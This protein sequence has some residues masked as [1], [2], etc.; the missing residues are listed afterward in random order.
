MAEWVPC[1]SGLIEADVIRWSEGIWKQ[2]PRKRGRAVNLGD[3]LVIA[4]V[5]RDDGEWVDLVVHDC[6]VASEMT[7]H[8]VA[9]LTTNA[10]VR[11]KRHTIEKGSPGRLLWS[12]E[13]V[14]A[15]LVCRLLP[16]DNPSASH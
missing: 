12:D 6:T 1:S 7:R 11:R 16:T 13:T 2:P 15:L 10:A 14:R 3:R 9:P 5:I 4:E 8:H